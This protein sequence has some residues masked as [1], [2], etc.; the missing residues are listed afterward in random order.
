MPRSRACRVESPAFTSTRTLGTSS[1]LSSSGDSAEAL[2]LSAL[3]AR[4]T[5]IV[6]LLDAAQIQLGEARDTLSRYQDALDLD[7]ERLAEVEAQIAK[8]H[9]LSRKHRVPMA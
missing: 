5:P 8:L 6:E 3:D 2:R 4:M 1:A 7:P 9:E